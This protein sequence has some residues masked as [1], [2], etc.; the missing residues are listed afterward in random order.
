MLRE[1]HRLR[2]PLGIRF[3][4][5][6]SVQP[7]Y[8]G[9]EVCV[10]P[11]SRPERRYFPVITPAGVYAFHGLPGLFQWE[12]GTDNSA[13]V[14]ELPFILSVRD[15][16]ARYSSAAMAIDLPWQGDGFLLSTLSPEAVDQQAPG[17]MLFS[18][19]DR[20][21]PA[22]ATVVDCQLWDESAQ[23]AAAFAVV[24][25]SEGNDGR[26]W[27]GVADAKGTVRIVF[28]SFFSTR[29]R[30]R[31]RRVEDSMDLRLAVR[32]EPGVLQSLPGINT[33]D[34]SSV[35]S[36]SAAR[37]RET[38]D[39]DAEDEIEFELVPGQLFV[40]RTEGTSVLHVVTA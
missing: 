26:M 22:W 6:S 12:H 3:W 35:F 18:S 40:L 4:D 32:Y 38:I 23:A 25:L 7:V 9:L 10:Y 36:Q 34:L 30:R 27:Y 29:G 1:I 17:F 16:K 21:P 8:D 24:E 11:P 28:P 15:R 19:A 13:S 20:Q 33:P 14:P 31:R 2:T 5:A 39:G 37:I